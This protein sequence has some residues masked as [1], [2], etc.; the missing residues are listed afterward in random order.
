MRSFSALA[1][2]SEGKPLS[3]SSKGRV[4]Y[5]VSQELR[6]VARQGQGTEL[7]R[8]GTVPQPPGKMSSEGP[9]TGAKFDRASGSPG[10]SVVMR[11]V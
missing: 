9:L 8:A 10:K 7:A 11:H 6:L 4:S 3:G 5:R 2:R 1:F